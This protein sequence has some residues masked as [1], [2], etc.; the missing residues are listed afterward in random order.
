M[1]NIMLICKYSE[2]NSKICKNHYFVALLAN[3]SGVL[4]V[5]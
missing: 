4:Q 5:V 3:G 1:K 2:K